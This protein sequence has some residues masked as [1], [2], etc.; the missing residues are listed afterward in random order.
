MKILLI[1]LIHFLGCVIYCLIM[2]NKIGKTEFDYG[3]MEEYTVN[4]GTIALE[5]FFWPLSLLRV[6]VFL[7]WMILKRMIEIINNYDKRRS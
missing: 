3:L 7:P 1:L 4:A 6:I 5:S 2:H